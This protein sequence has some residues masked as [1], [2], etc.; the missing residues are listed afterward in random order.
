ME[1][2]QSLKIR[3]GPIHD[4]NLTWF[5]NE[6]I[7]NVNIMNFAVRDPDESWISPFRSRSVCSFTAPLALRNQAHGKTDE[8]RSILDVRCI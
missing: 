8:H 4:I 6:V 1:L 5:R 7:K 3:I 2:I